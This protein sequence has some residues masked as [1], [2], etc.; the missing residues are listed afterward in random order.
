M[1]S[2]RYESSLR[3]SCMHERSSGLTKC[4]TPETVECTVAPP[5]SSEVTTSWVTVLTTS[6]P[7]MCMYEVS[8][9]MAMKSV[10]AGL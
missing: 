3:K 4:A 6:G 1:F 10:I 2:G 7:V 8:S 5:R 9:T